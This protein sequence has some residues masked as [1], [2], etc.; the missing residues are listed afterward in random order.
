MFAF[1]VMKGFSF[2]KLFLAV[3][4]AIYALLKGLR[5]LQ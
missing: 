4:I 3:S 5:R 1:I 2:V